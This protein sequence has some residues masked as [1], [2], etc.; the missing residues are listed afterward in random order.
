MLMLHAHH[1]IVEQ[2][3]T[4]CMCMC[5]Y[6]KTISLMIPSDMIEA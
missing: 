4:V 6:C 1:N 2:R 5:V 3:S